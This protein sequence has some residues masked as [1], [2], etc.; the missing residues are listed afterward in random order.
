MIEVRRYTNK[1]RLLKISRRVCQYGANSNLM[2]TCLRMTLPQ[3]IIRKAYNTYTGKRSYANISMVKNSSFFKS[4]YPRS[5]L[6]TNFVNMMAPTLV[7]FSP[8]CLSLNTELQVY[9][10]SPF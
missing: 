9:Y 2:E 10:I 5:G 3:V 6:P 7:I 8:D 1:L 4:I